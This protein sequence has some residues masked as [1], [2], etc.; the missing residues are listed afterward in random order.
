MT[1]NPNAKNQVYNVAVGDRTTLNTVF[2]SLKDN[3]VPYGVSSE[4]KP[5]YRDFRSGDVRHSQADVS[6]ISELLGYRFSHRIGDGLVESIAWY[7]ENLRGSR[8]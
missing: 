7:V 2:Q 3:L 6:K 8:I 4:T 5:I 1:D